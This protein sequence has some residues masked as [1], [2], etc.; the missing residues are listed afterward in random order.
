M[1][2]YFIYLMIG[3]LPIIAFGQVD[4]LDKQTNEGGFFIPDSLKSLIPIIKTIFI[5]RC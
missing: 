5:K 1:K 3:F 2:K 4:Q